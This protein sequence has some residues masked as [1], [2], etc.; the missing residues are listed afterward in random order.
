MTPPRAFVIGHP[1]AH[2]RS[3]LLH[4]HW[5]KTI[6]LAGSYEKIDVAPEVLKDFVAGMA[7]AGFAGGN[8]TVPHKTAMLDLVDDLD[9]VGMPGQTERLCLASQ[10]IGRDR[11]V[12]GGGAQQAKPVAYS[13]AT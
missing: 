8:V 1:I 3:P 6:G 9:D 11:V 10:P 13:T 5:L 4:G 2:S 7:Q 12:R